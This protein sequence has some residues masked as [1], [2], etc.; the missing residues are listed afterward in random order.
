VRESRILPW[1]PRSPKGPST[2]RIENLWTLAK[3][4]FEVRC[5]IEAGGRLGWMVRVQMNQ[6]WGF[7]CEFTTRS[8]ALEAAEIKFF[9]LSSTGWTP[10]TS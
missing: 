7:Q 8:A 1:R 6:Q 4:D 10:A 2:G 5:A 3:Q 9:E